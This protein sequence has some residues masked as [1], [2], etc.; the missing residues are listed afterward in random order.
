MLMIKKI[1]LFL[2]VVLVI[3]TGTAFSNNTQNYKDEVDLAAYFPAQAG[4]NYQFRGEGNEFASFE[5]ELMYVKGPFLQLRDM[6]GTSMAK[7]YKIEA[8]QISLISSQAEFYEDKNLLLDLNKETKIDEIILKKPLKKGMQWETNGRLKE[9]TA[10][11]MIV[12][13]PAGIF[14]DVITV[15]ISYLNQESNN[16]GFDYYAKNI[17]LIKS[18][19]IIAADDYKIVSELETFNQLKSNVQQ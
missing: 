1:I 7:I 4:R 17:G 2:I 18:E 10:T 16:F 6:S 13:V 12:E 11:D 5:R 9:I 8:D 15:K 3:L 14:H 19:Y